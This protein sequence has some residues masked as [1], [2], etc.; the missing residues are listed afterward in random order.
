FGAGAAPYV[1]PRDAVEETLA[2]IYA[3][4]LRVPQVGVHDDFFVLGGHSLRA[5]QVAARVRATLEVEL[6]VRAVFEEPTVA[7][8]ADRV[9][10]GSGS[11]IIEPPLQRVERS[12]PLPASFAQTRLWFLAQLEPDSPT[13]NLPAFLRLDGNVDVDVLERACNE[14]LQRHESLRT[15]FLAVDGEPH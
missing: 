12:A 4:V 1:G 7:G 5:T 8:L 6:P 9:R 3:E 10:A 15:T 11:R 2:G 13:Y 14:L